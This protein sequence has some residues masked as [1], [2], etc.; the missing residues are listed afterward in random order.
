MAQALIPP[1]P[2]SR[3]GIANC[4]PT[5]HKSLAIALEG[6]LLSAF[7]KP[8]SQAFI[9]ALTPQMHCFSALQER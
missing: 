5:T 8:S 4:L 1:A 3:Q 9:L 7:H 6:M 2:D